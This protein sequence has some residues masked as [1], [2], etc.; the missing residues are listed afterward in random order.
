MRDRAK[1]D[2]C[3]ECNTPLD[4][5]KDDP[6]AEYKS[7]VGLVCVLISL[8]LLPAIGFGSLLFLGFGLY[9]HLQRHSL[10]A[11]YRASYT[12]IRR[13]KMVKLLCWVWVGEAVAIGLIASVWA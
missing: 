11:T 6:V 2:R 10:T 4:I 7:R 5:R 8:A 1:G 13:R 12:T 3:P 9:K